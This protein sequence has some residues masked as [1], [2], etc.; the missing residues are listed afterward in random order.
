MIR[1]ADNQ[2]VVVLPQ[3]GALEQLGARCIFPSIDVAYS[4]TTGCIVQLDALHRQQIRHIAI[5]MIVCPCNE[6][7]PPLDGPDGTLSGM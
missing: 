5:H 4:L 7:S 2:S 1:P 6:R 3:E